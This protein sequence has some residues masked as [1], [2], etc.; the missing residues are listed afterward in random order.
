ME[1]DHPE[2]LGVNGKIILKLI[3]KKWGRE[4]WA[5]FFWLRIGAVGRALV[6]A[7]MNPCAVETMTSLGPVIRL[8]RVKMI[9][10]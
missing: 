5:G 9:E 2:D 4:K 10:K 6:I 8:Q 1:R 3:L 7:V